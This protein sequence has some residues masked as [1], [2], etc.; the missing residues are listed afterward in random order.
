MVDHP[1]LNYLI[2]FF[3]LFSYV[4]IFDVSLFLGHCGRLVTLFS[5]KYLAPEMLSMDDQ[6]DLSALVDNSSR[7]CKA[8]IFSLGITIFELVR[9]QISRS[10][11]TFASSIHESMTLTVFQASESFTNAAIP[12]NRSLINDADIVLPSEHFTQEFVDLLRVRETGTFYRSSSPC[13]CRSM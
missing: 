6:F 13:H 3:Q 4:P 7:L 11:S 5:G 9:S 8:D 10:L 12:S 2:H 1:L